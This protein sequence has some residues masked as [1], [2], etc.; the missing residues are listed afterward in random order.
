MRSEVVTP[1]R[2]VHRAFDVEMTGGYG[3]IVGKR[4]VATMWKTYAP[5]PGNALVVDG[6][7]YVIDSPPIEDNGV[8]VTVIL[9]AA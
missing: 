8:S 4:V 5:L 9:R 2:R 7:N 6:T 1:L 3:E